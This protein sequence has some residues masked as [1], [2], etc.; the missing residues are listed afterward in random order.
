MKQFKSY[1]ICH[2]L[3]AVRHIIAV[4]VCVFDTLEVEVYK[5]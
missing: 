2:Y 5:S 1:I 4:C 3:Y